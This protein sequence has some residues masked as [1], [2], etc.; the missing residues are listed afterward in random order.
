M[1]LVLPSAPRM[2]WFIGIA[3]ML[4]WILVA[5]P[6]I[7]AQQVSGSSDGL[8]IN[9]RIPFESVMSYDEVCGYE[10]DPRNMNTFLE[11]DITA[12][13]KSEQA[14][15]NVD[16]GPGFTQE[17]RQAF[18]RAVD[19]WA[20]HIQSPVPITIDAS[21][22]DLGD[23]VLASAGPRFI[24]TVTLA[25]GSEVVYGDALVN[26]LTGE[27]QSPNEPDIIVNV[28]SNRSD[29]YFGEDAPASNE[30]DFTSV[31]LHEIGHGLNFFNLTSVDNGEGSWGI[32]QGPDRPEDRKVPGAL[33]VL[34]QHESPSGVFNELIN[35]SIYPN[36]S[37]EL[38][39]A[40][41]SN[42]LFASGPS[43]DIAAE[44]STGPI[45][46]QIYAPTNYQ[47]GSSIAHFDE[48]TYPA[49]DPN[50][51]MTPQ[52]G[53]NEVAR[54]PG[55]L[56]CGLL[57]DMGWELAPNCAA[58]VGAEVF[59]FEAQAESR[60][61]NV[62][63]SWQTG[64]AASDIDEYI[65]RQRKFDGDFEEVA[66]LPGGADPQIELD[67]LAMGRYTYQLQWVRGGEVDGQSVE[68]P[69]VEINVFDLSADVE[70]PVDNQGRTSVSLDWS[71][72][73]D[74]ADFVFEVE[75]APGA[76]PEPED[77]EV[78]S[79]S[80]LTT[81]QERLDLQAAGSYQYRVRST[82]AEGN[83]LT[84]EPITAQVPFEAPVVFTE[85]Y[86]NPSQGN[87]T[88]DL[89]AAE[90]QVVTVEVYN[91]LGQ[92]VYRDRIGLQRN[93]PR[94]LQLE[95]SRLGSG[96]HF[97]RITGSDFVETRQVA[98]VR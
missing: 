45:P 73:P 79:T 66:R 81:A 49:G 65:V 19:I 27:N 42:A 54:T 8:V 87:F 1:K 56:F 48:L 96:M 91:T 20:T 51:L 90:S 41:T 4:A 11:A 92:R 21:F 22:Q 83:V 29:W 78:A 5:A 39:D 15:I 12:V 6:A 37:T 7:Q 50:A 61:G 17:A 31:I 13:P 86:P 60:T 89:T 68:E 10:N 85:A 2:S 34:L 88:F 9:E 30:I 94:T 33:E 28:N 71:T 76:S 93:V 32:G 47:P 70:T 69:V 25:D 72:P 14:D 77:F 95:T 59:A 35:R 97:V 46:A 24:Y 80:E 53:F 64:P 38:G 44:N 3:G 57:D 16:Y 74:V 62:V 98:L 82:D 55:P 63:L 75:R 52:I 23:G 43:L 58:A 84:S 67:N 18:Q 40:L 36:P 26:A